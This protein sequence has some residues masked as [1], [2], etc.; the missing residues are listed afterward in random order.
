M[1]VTRSTRTAIA[2]AVLGLGLLGAP[3]IASAAPAAHHAAVVHVAAT[4]TASKSTPKATSTT[5][6]KPVTTPVT[7]TYTVVA[8]TFR[9][10]AL[11][12]KRL[13]SITAKGINGLSVVKI[14]KTARS[15]RFRVEETGLARADA[16]TLWK[17]LRKAHFFAYYT[18]R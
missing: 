1:S 16:K 2:A 8:G 7:K 15:T 12:D 14:G 10:Q 6:P 3:A 4:A 18:A 11:A 5:T 9:T 17:Q 13:A